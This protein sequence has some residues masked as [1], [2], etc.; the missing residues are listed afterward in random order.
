[1]EVGLDRWCQDFEEKGIGRCSGC[2]GQEYLRRRQLL[3]ASWPGQHAGSPCIHSLAL[4]YGESGHTYFLSQDA[5]EF[6]VAGTRFLLLCKKEK[7]IV[8]FLL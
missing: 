2:L 1:M 3:T 5:L 8:L 4:L 6:A 7:K